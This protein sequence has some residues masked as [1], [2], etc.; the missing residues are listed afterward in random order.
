LTGDNVKYI[1]LCQ[2]RLL[3]Q[4]SEELLTNPLSKELLASTPEDQK[5][6][7]SNTPLAQLPRVKK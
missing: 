7:F 5:Y 3:S 6:V 2:R 4:I 1:E